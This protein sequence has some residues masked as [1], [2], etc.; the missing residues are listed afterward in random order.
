MT[1]AFP[2]SDHVN[3][4]NSRLCVSEEGFVEFVH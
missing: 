1:S 4:A 3:H 2:G